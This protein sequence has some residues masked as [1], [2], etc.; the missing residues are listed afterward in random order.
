M[1]APV[2]YKTIKV[3]AATHRQIHDLANR[4]GGSADDALAQILSPYTV[5]IPLTPAQYDR[6]TQGA[7]AAG[8][9]LDQFAQLRVEAALMF[10][11]DPGAI[12]LMYRNIAALCTAAGITPAQ[13]PR[14]PPVDR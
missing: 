2:Q 11:T 1:T 5:R 6:W 7:R 4:L 13:P 9:S 14:T 3:S 10:G 12:G 8:V